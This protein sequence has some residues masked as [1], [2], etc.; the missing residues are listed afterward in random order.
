MGNL[1]RKSYPRRSAEGIRTKPIVEKRR[2]RGV[3]LLLGVPH[4]SRLC[5]LISVLC[6][7]GCVGDQL[8]GVSHRRGLDPR[9][10]YCRRNLLDRT[11]LPRRTLHLKG[12][13]T[14]RMIMIRTR[15]ETETVFQRSR[16]AK[17]PGRFKP[18][19]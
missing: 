14:G 10:A 17:F 11:S 1:M 3:D 16:G 2:T 13:Q 9:V 7:D 12:S 19:S 8:V 6:P 15:F 4:A 18:N 5:F